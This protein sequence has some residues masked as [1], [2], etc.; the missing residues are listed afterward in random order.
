MKRIICL[1]CIFVSSVAA[2]AQTPEEII[3]KMDEVMAARMGDGV[4]MT[5]D[6]KIP[7]LGSVS[8]RTYTRKGKARIE[9]SMGGEKVISFIDGTTQWTWNSSS[10][11]VEIETVDPGKTSQ[12]RGDI[13]LFNGITEG[14]DVSI[15]KETDKE[16]HLLCNK[17][18]DNKEKD[19]PKTI[20]LVVSKGTFH[21]RSLSTK[22]SGIGVTMRDLSFNVSERQVTFNPDDF[23]GATIKDKRNK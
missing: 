19:A 7:L 4:A 12:E 5:V 14:Y 23:P 3:S 9:A 22:V 2:L 11:V 10:N 1:F 17:K 16:W 21:P 6:I 18:R 20:D 15:D 8:S 13:G